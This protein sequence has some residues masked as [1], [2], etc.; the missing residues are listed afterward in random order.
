M[1]LDESGAAADAVVPLAAGGAEGAAADA[2]VAAAVDEGAAGADP[3]GAAEAPGADDAAAAVPGFGGAADAAS[4]DRTSGRA[5]A[6]I[7]V[8]PRRIRATPCGSGQIG[9][10]NALGRACRNGLTSV[11]P[12]E[13]RA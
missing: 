1:P 2:V 5:K 12:A 7:I 4:D 10:A 11:A 9:P 3:G 13:A 8:V 6:R